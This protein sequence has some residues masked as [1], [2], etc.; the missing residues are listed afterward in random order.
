MIA[1]LC[2]WVIILIS[3]LYIHYGNSIIHDTINMSTD[4]LELSRE[5]GTAECR[6]IIALE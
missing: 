4:F 6:T 5:K 1:F 2:D 3:L